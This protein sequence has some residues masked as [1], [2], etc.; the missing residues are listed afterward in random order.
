MSSE[1]SD[2]VLLLPQ[3]MTLSLNI[4]DLHVISRA[5]ALKE[6]VKSA[7]S[8]LTYGKWNIYSSD[9]H[10]P[11]LGDKVHMWKETEVGDME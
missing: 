8:H 5:R 10:F 7:N 2:L 11:F 3:L 9:K 6:A 4:Y 1:K